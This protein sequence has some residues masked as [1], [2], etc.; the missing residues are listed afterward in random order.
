M[1]TKRRIGSSLFAIS[2]HPS[3]VGG[4]R[5]P[6]A[7]RFA[8]LIVDDLRAGTPR[9]LCMPSKDGHHFFK[10]VKPGERFKPD[11]EEQNKLTS[12][13]SRLMAAPNVHPKHYAKIRLI[14][15]SESMGVFG[16]GDKRFGRTGQFG[17]L[18]PNDGPEGSSDQ[19]QF[20]LADRAAI[21]N[22]ADPFNL[23]YD[24][25]EGLLAV[26]S[27]QSSSFYPL[28]PRTVRTAVTVRDHKNRY[29]ARSSNPDTYPIKFVRLT[30]VELP[31]AQGHTQTTVD[32]GDCECEEGGT[33]E[34]GFVHNIIDP[35]LGDAYIPEGTLIFVYNT[36]SDHYRLNQWFTQF[37]CESQE[38]SASV[39]ESSISASCPSNSGD[40]SESLPSNSSGGSS[41]SS[42][43]SSSGDSSLSSSRGSSLSSR[44]SSGSSS[45]GSSLSSSGFDC[46]TVV[47]TLSYSP[48]TCVLTA[49]RRQICFPAWLGIEVGD[50]F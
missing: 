7:P 32:S 11:A 30:Y 29:P 14:K 27:E 2:Q 12:A 41:L 19:E 50:E 37:C 1:A 46:V 48:T 31:G 33:C 24:K 17:Y 26:Y 40:F 25:D 42:S 15:L 36:A 8:A 18:Y 13:V 28:N 38:S 5:L 43:L 34:D 21:A 4:E 49:Y 45:R 35:T 23:I 6:A 47:T 44:G 22:I 10:Q 9:W 3:A 16:T 20:L 39:S